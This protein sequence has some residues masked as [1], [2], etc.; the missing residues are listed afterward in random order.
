MSKLA[1]KDLNLDKLIQS[2]PFA[3]DAGGRGGGAP[4]MKAF[5]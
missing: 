5:V 2:Q 1:R 3:H 4:T